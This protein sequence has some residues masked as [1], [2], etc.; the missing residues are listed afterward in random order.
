LA[1]LYESLVPGASPAEALELVAGTEPE[2]RQVEVDLEALTAAA[3]HAPAVAARL[4][5]S[6]PPSRDELGELPGGG[7]FRAE[8]DRFL[9]AHGHLGQVTDDLLEPSWL[10]DPRPL[11]GDVGTRLG[12]RT[13]SAAE[14]AV[15]RAAVADRRANE[16]RARLAGRPAELAA[17]EA[18]LAQAREIGHLTE[19]HN[20]W[21]DRMANDRLRRLSRRV[22]RR[23]VA[24][25]VLDDAEDVVFLRRH[26]VAE[27]IRQ[28]GDRRSVVVERRA[29][30]ARNAAIVAPKNVGRMPDKDAT[31]KVDRFE[32]A[33]PEVR[34]G[35]LVRGTGA[36]A[37]IARGV[38]R[39]VRGP[40]DFHRVEPGDIVV[41]TTSNPGW[42]PLFAIAGGFITDT[43][44]V[45]SHAAVVARE[46]GV[47]AVVGT[48]D[49]TGRIVDG[50]TIELDGTSGVVRIR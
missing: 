20:Y 42:V 31:A 30:H 24:D 49:G 34:T 3:Q 16:V 28:P 6:P 23:L 8:L 43:G 27:V 39:V 44:G 18:L 13:K 50:S 29:V 5:S 37:G 35:E 12:R 11:L 40:A 4:R 46:F 2:M 22:G 14:R 21:I 15:E 45:L 38:A 25:G 1:D 33:R 26:E 7:P 10:E 47:P 36:S 19:G 32:G 17:F 9:T 41:A 48:G